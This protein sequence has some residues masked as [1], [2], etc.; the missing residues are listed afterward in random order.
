[1]P[2]I[3]GHTLSDHREMTRNRLFRALRDLMCEL[4]FDAITMSMIAARADV[5]RTAVYNHFADKEVLLLAF[6][7]QTTAE[8]AQH[9]T[10]A[11]AGHHDPVDQLKIYIHAHL[12]MSEEF[13]LPHGLNLRQQV[14]DHNMHRLHH[15]ADM[16]AQLLRSILKDAVKAGSIPA[17]DP[18]M[19]VTLIHASLAGHRLPPHGQQ[20][21]AWIATIQAFV[22]RG[23]GV[24]SAD[25]DF[26]FDVAECPHAGHESGPEYSGH[27]A[28]S[29]HHGQG[30]DHD[31]FAR[32]PV[33]H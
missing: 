26:P 2:K 21:R 9:L 6:M 18:Q 22:L 20:R 11:L 29:G 14:S 8:F 28:H 3:L 16:I 31:S 4:P 1:M 15:H 17:Q 30:I 10:H 7:E 13:H 27:S 33:H 25:T 5:G 19:M 32:C 12:E 24:V 23:L